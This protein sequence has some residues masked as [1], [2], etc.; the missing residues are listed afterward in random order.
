MS[1]SIGR[2]DSDLQEWT[3]STAE[4]ARRNARWRSTSPI[5]SFRPPT[6]NKCAVTHSVED[7]QRA[8]RLFTL[9]SSSQFERKGKWSG[10]WRE[11]GEW[12]KSENRS[13]QIRRERTD[14]C[15]RAR[16][17]W[18]PPTGRRMNAA[19]ED[20]AKQ[21]LVIIRVS[22]LNVNPAEIVA[23]VASSDALI[24]T[25]RMA[26]LRSSGSIREKQTYFYASPQGKR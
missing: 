18:P 19:G 22:P 5:F 10:D 25:S 7:E 17:P 21:H 15:C 11:I 1:R 9:K 14:P 2:D 24:E 4:E 6:R 3:A 8:T 23:V 12:G 13:Q 26:S 16:P 20:E